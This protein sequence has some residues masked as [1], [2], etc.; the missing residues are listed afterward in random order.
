MKPSVDIAMRGLIQ[1]IRA[2]LPFDLPE[3]QICNGPCQGCSLKLLGFLESELDDWQ[4]RL[5][6]GGKPGLAELSQLMR[7]S[8]KVGRVLE[9][10]GVNGGG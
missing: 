2:E 1:R 6:Q 5:A 10:A 9:K 8:R 4:E 3:A 7:T